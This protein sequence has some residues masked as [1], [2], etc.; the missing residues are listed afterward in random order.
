VRVPATLSSLLA[1]AIPFASGCTDAQLAEAPA[2]AA[3]PATT[4][5]LSGQFC[6]GTPDPTAYP[7]RILFVVDIS[8]SMAESDPAPPGCGGVCLTHRAQAI[9]DTL[10]KYPP[11]DSVAYGVISFASNASILTVNPTTTLPGFTN[12]PANVISALPQLAAINGQT[13]YDGALQLAYQ[14]L[15]TDMNQLGTTQKS[16]A[17]YEIVFM[18]DGAPDP[19]TAGPGQSIGPDVRADV[20][21]IEALQTQQQLAAVSLNTIYVYGGDPP[22]LAS[23]QASTLLSSMASLANGQ[24]RE[25]DSSEEFNLFYIDFSAFVRSYVLKS[26]VVSNVTERPVAGPGGQGTVVHPD[27]DGDGLDDA[28][29]AL[30]GTSPLLSDTDGD[31][32]S[33]YLEYQLRNSGFNPLYPDDADCVETTDKEDYDG[34]GLRNCEERYIGTSLQLADS[35]GDGYSDDLEYFNGTNPVIA[36]NLGD[37]DFDRAP[38]GFELGNHTDP[39]RD[40]SADF[41]QISYRYAMQAIDPGAGNEDAGLGQICYRFNVDNVALAPA[42]STVPGANGGGTNTVLLRVLTSPVDDPTAPG[43]YQVAC[44]RP[45]FTGSAASESPQSGSMTVPLGAFKKPGLTDGGVGFD[46]H[47]DCIVP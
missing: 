12:D 43:S 22:P 45:R 13:S 6:T 18:S 16:G 19:N 4:L 44:V 32:F 47:R 23:F 34:D 11:S 1:L 27:T 29:E 42:L 9:Y 7:V 20:L 39:R 35:D 41:S 5:S 10:Q 28:T 2:A 33:D 21:N 8:G 17:K 37:L 14:M 40:D 30:V 24:Y 46:E 3:G 38:N 31:G 25:F 26:F 36:D 15:L